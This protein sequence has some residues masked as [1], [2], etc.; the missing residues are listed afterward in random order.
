MSTVTLSLTNA[1][2][3][4]WGL[5]TEEEQP[6]MVVWLTEEQSTQDIDSAIL[7]D[8]DVSRIIHS[9]DAGILEVKGLENYESISQETKVPRSS[10]VPIVSPVSPKVAPSETIMDVTQLMRQ[11]AERSKVIEEKIRN[12][13][14]K[15]NELLSMPAHK[16]KKEIKSLAKGVAPIS[17][18][19]ELRKKEIEGKD[20]KTVIAVLT[21]VI[22][23]KINAVGIDGRPGM[24][25]GQT[26]LSEAYYDMIEEFEDEDEPEDVVE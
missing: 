20:R 17:L 6:Q 25:T 7:T 19:Q 1:R 3:A 9:R 14:P 13:Y 11:E 5:L 23:S 8:W 24:H 15:I 21:E 4:P 10:A 16:L 18:F 22:Q 26:A 2:H 12:R